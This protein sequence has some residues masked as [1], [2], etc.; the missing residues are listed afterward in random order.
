MFWAVFG[1]SVFSFGNLILKHL[2][3]GPFFYLVSDSWPW[4]H[5]G[6]SWGGGFTSHT[7]VSLLYPRGS[8]LVHQGFS[9]R[10]WDFSFQKIIMKTLQMASFPF[11]SPK[12]REE[13][14]SVAKGNCRE[15]PP[16]ASFMLR[17]ECWAVS[18]WFLVLHMFRETSLVRNYRN[19]A[20]K[21][22]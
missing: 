4:S 12:G 7:P 3:K 16:R 2:P 22:Y 8:D 20:W 17:S 15:A 11:H 19:G 21:C 13:W 10:Y 18:S 1:Y 6:H 5:T 14:S 9:T